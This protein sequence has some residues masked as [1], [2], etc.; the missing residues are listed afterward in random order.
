MS[1]AHSMIKILFVVL[2]FS[3]LARAD[4]P[5]HQKNAA[6]DTKSFTERVTKSAI[7]QKNQF[8]E[9]DALPAGK[10]TIVAFAE[11]KDSQDPSQ[12]DLELNVFKFQNDDKYS[13]STIVA[14]EQEGGSPTLR[15]FFYANADSTPQKS[16]GVICGWDARHESDC[17]QHDQV[18]F[19]KVS[20]SGELTQL[21][22][23]GFEKHLYKKKK[24]ITQENGTIDCTLANFKNAK[25]VK[26]ILKKMGFPQK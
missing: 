20:S 11:L 25:D 2:F 1:T 6:E 26:T 15:S 19:F 7:H 23:Q 16:I 3:G 17:Q 24:T 21:N 14:C 5:F 10:K 12:Y 22:N 18:R 9:T 8:A 4:V 13:L